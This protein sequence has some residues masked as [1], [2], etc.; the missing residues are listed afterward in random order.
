[1]AVR[2][3]LGAAITLTAFALAGRRVWM[4]Y[5]LGRAMQLTGAAHSTPGA[6]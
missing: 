2:L 4:L 3:I 1:M 6:S 5:R